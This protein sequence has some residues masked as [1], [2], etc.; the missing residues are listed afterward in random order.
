MKLHLLIYDWDLSQFNYVPQDHWEDFPSQEIF[1]T[2][3]L[4]KLKINE[5]EDWFTVTVSVIQK[6]G[7][8]GLFQ[9]YGSLSKLLSTFYPE[10]KK[11]C[12]D[13][14]DNA[15]HELNLSKVEDVAKFP[16]YLHEWNGLR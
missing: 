12:R 13:A 11:A 4:K 3:L 6:H 7:G 5:S 1:M 2:N 8:N 15:V 16:M 9:K 14:V 10:Y